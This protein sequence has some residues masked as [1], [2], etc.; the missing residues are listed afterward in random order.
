SG[1]TVERI[2]NQI[3]YEPLNL[4]PLRAAGAPPQ[5]FDLISRCTA[6]QP[7]QRP[8]GLG[9]V[10]TE[11]EAL[12]DPQRMSPTQ[13]RPPTVRPELGQTGQTRQSQPTGPTYAQ[14]QQPQPQHRPQPPANRPRPSA[15]LE[16]MPGF[17]KMLP[18]ALQTQGGLIALA[19][20][21]TLLLI[22]VVYLVLSF[23]KVI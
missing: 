21:L 4:D 5:L 15:D 2:F 22:I 18:G 9:I 11:L 13:Q 3:L 20:G 16:G 6:K 7:A 23:A 14:Q 1:D 17:V 8:Q 19:G 10:A 12:L